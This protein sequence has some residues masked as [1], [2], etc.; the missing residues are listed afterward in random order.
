MRLVTIC[1]RCILVFF[2]LI[3]VCCSPAKRYKILKVFFD[4]VP[5]PGTAKKEEE[6]S[7]PKYSQ[8]HIKKKAIPITSRHPDYFKNICDKCHDRTA[9]NFLKAEKNRICFTCHQEDRFNSKFVHGPV[10]VRDCLA[11]HL[12]HESPYKKLLKKKCNVLCLEC[13]DIED[14]PE[15]K[16]HYIS[17]KGDC[18]DCHDPHTSDSQFFIKKS[19]G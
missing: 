14:T 12:P 16:N 7:R 8:L 5:E 19:T 13:H 10:A 3:S 17:K 9:S 6:I 18:V 1:S 11:C 2:L 4:G 15:A